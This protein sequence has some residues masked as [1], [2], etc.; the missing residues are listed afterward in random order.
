MENRN[1]QEAR[2]IS[3]VLTD[4]D[5]TL[6]GKDKVLTERALGAVKSL[7]ERGIIFTITSGRPPFGMRALVEPLGLTMP[8]AAFNGA[9]IALP[10]LSILDERQLPGYLVPALIDMIQAHGLDIFLFR[11]NDWYVRSL[12]VPH[13]SR[14]ASIIQRP[15]VV[16]SNFESVLTGVV[17]VVGVSDDHPRVAACEAAVQKQFGTHVSAACSQP[18]YLDVTHPSA[19]KGVVIER[20]SR[21]LKIPMDRIAVLGDQASDVLMFRKSGLSIAMGNASDEVK[22]Q[23]TFVTTSFG[24]EGFANAVEQFILPRAEP[25]G[26]PAVKATGQLHRLGQSLWLDNITRDLLDSGTLQHYIDELSVTG[27]T[28]NPTIFEHAIKNSSTYDT[29][30]RKKLAEGKSGEALFFE[31]ALEDLTRAADMFRPIYDRTNGV[32][33]WVSVEVSPLLAY[34]TASTLAAAKELHARADRP[35]LFIK[36]PGTREGLP[37]IEEAIFAGVPINITLLFSREQYLAAAEAF[38][39]GVERRVDA[40]L[41]PNVGSVASVFVSRWDSAVAAKVPAELRSRLGIAM[42]QRTYKAY[43]S[44]LS[45][46]RWQRIYNTGAYPQRLLWAST[47]TKDPAASDVLYI[48]SLAAPFTV[49]TMPEGTLK[50]L[51]DHGAITTLL[52][53]D[54][55]NCEE[56]LAQVASSGVDVYAL[57]V[58]LQDEGA[59]AFVKSWDGLMSQIN[60]KTAVL[61]KAAG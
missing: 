37:A 34:N 48:K 1:A 40:G 50:A 49:N 10:D 26:G 23:A 15:P 12:D 31:V 33:G 43:R 58:E 2:S 25:A 27:L 20:L 14:E 61:K 22:R 6:L 17:K 19:N 56:V 51:A 21:Y 45:S 55:G 5:G 4:V 28:S 53:A 41:K 24:E 35:N 42:A 47:G 57:A 9:V 16:A 30:I 44:L 32:D 13:A 39:R 11:S 7:R 29:T 59:K 46:P 52:Q 54:G 18:Y 60:S 3:A 8:M 36:I 38:L